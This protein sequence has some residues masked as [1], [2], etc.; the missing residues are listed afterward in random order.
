MVCD[1]GAAKAKVVC[2]WRRSWGSKAGREGDGGVIPTTTGHIVS[3][4]HA[5]WWQASAALP[6]PGRS[7]INHA[8]DRDGSA[9]KCHPLFVDS[10][11]S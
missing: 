11:A 3:R 4:D 2:C 7:G 10:V 1:G 9:G 5:I 8:C 6:F